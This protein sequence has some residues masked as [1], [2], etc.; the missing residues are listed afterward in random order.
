MFLSMLN[1]LCLDPVTDTHSC[2]CTNHTKLP[3]SLAYVYGIGS[4]VTDSALPVFLKNFHGCAF[5][6]KSTACT[7]RL[8]S[9]T[10]CNECAVALLAFFSTPTFLLFYMEKSVW[11]MSCHKHQL[12]ASQPIVSVQ[13]LCLCKAHHPLYGTCVGCVICCMWHIS[14]EQERMEWAILLIWTYFIHIK[15]EL[16]ETVLQS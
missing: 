2:I 15:E 13:R 7:Q 11:R 6:Y 9:S 5:L 10:H 4:D 12:W 8:C 14:T 16:T 3:R 1:S